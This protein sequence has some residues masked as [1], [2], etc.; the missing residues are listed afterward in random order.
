MGK[1]L[2]IGGV[3][4]VI[5]GLVIQFSGKIPW[6]GKLPGD[7]KI[8]RENFTFYF[9]VMTSVILSILISLILFFLNK[10]NR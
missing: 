1:L 10:G 3:I 4:L 2:I 6:L 5:V 8:Q 9:P 7:I